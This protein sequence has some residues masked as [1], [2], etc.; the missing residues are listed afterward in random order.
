M[1]E[2]EAKLVHKQLKTNTTTNMAAPSTSASALSA[3][4]HTP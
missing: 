4:T 3:V 1:K 2:Q